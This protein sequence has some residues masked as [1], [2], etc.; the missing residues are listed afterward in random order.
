M[1][2]LNVQKYNVYL[3]QHNINISS[4]LRAMRIFLVWKRDKGS[5]LFNMANLFSPLPTCYRFAMIYSSPLLHKLHSQQIYL[6][7]CW[8]P[9]CLQSTDDEIS[10]Q[11]YSRVRASNTTMPLKR[12]FCPRT[13]SLLFTLSLTPYVPL[14]HLDRLS[15]H[16]S[17]PWALFSFFFVSQFALSDK[18]EQ[19]SDTCEEV[20]NAGKDE[21]IYD[22]RPTGA[23]KRC[24]IEM[25]LVLIFLEGDF[26]YF[27][28]M[29]YL[30]SASKKK[31]NRTTAPSND[32]EKISA[33]PLQAGK[34]I[35]QIACYWPI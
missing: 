35:P 19:Y 6:F 30:F 7:F 22:R 10:T 26:L 9:I 8:R 12:T 23:G 31:V 3:H 33:Y 25:V 13:S 28:P 21:T 1:S 24:Y 18:C 32:I 17:S 16:S 29:F 11:Y 27:F 15:F 14:P 34:F 4:S 2:V 20:H 5:C